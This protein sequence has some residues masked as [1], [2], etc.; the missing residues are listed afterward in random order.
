MRCVKLSILA[1]L[2]LWLSPLRCQHLPS[3]PNFCAG[4][5]CISSGPVVSGEKMN[6]PSFSFSKKGGLEGDMYVINYGGFGQIEL[7]IKPATLVGCAN[8]GKAVSRLEAN[9]D[10][11]YYGQLCKVMPNGKVYLIY[12]SLRGTD[13]VKSRDMC[14][15]AFDGLWFFDSFYATKIVY[16]PVYTK[17]DFNFRCKK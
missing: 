1:F 9:G 8:A 11:I 5:L 13:F 16:K 6:Y 17:I 7:S 15:Q 3:M 2:M 14:E 12:A 10:K 4:N